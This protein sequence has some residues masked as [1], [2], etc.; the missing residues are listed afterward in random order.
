MGSCTQRN[1]FHEIDEHSHVT[2]VSQGHLV[3]YRKDIIIEMRSW[4]L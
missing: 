1:T 3:V 4:M 2:L